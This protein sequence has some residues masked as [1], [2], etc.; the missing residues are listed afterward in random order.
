[1]V[2]VK[3]VKTNAFVDLSVRGWVIFYGRARCWSFYI[4]NETIVSYLTTER[5]VM[6]RG[7]EGHFSYV[8]VHLSAVD[9]KEKQEKKDSFLGNEGKLF[10]FLYLCTIRRTYMAY[11]H[12]YKKKMKI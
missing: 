1:M 2:N 4:S 3:G 12:A 8:F 9:A 5:R 11:V 6:L 7:D 10:Y